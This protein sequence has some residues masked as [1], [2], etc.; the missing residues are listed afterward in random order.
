MIRLESRIFSS[1]CLQIYWYF[2]S[3]K[4]LYEC[5]CVCVCMLKIVNGKPG[6][7][8]EKRKRNVKKLSLIILKPNKILCLSFTKSI[9]YKMS[10]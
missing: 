6:E 5:V 3:R 4:N 2:T 1:A 9:Q 10:F 7:S 8:G